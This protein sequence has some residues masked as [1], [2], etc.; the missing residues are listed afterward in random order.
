MT[1]S[2]RQ[3]RTF[4]RWLA[5]AALCG[6]LPAV[7]LAQTSEKRAPR[8]AVASHE[9]ARGI[10]LS[11]TDIG[12]VPSLRP[13]N[14]GALVAS[15]QAIEPATESDSLVGWMTRRLITAGE[16]L[17]SPAVT[18]PQLVK[19]GDVVDVVFQS[20]SVSVTM[21]GKATR[22][23]AIG[24]RITVRMDNQRRLDGTV[25]ALGRVRVN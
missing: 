7:V 8:V 18:P 12:Y 15:A 23:A 4:A 10:V 14:P 20:E 11:H 21:R 19:S 17:R 22:S 13:A 16:P 1:I 3:R 24:E 6:A 9:I 5:I 2:S 25:I